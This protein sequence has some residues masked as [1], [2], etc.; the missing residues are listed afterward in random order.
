MI[1]L[2]MLVRHSLVSPG[3]PIDSN[4]IDFRERGE[5]LPVGKIL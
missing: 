2:F 3:Q 5:K 4:E 1:S